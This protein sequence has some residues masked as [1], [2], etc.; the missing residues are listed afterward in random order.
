MAKLVARHIP[1]DEPAANPTRVK[2]VRG[3]RIFGSVLLSVCHFK[4]NVSEVF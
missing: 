4:N 1:V 3:L 2:L